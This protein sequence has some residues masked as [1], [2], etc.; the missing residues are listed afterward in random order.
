MRDITITFLDL[1]LEP[2]FCVNNNKDVKQTF[3][4]IKNKRNASLGSTL[5]S[6]VTPI[7]CFFNSR[8]GLVLDLVDSG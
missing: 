1:V 6:S 5:P 7:R 4:C 2:M 8:S 3:C